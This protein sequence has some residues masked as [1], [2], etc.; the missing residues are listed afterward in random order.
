MSDYPLLLDFT[1]LNESLKNFHRLSNDELKKQDV[2]QAEDG[3]LNFGGPQ[4]TIFIRV[5]QVCESSFPRM[6]PKSRTAFV[7]ALN[8]MRRK[9]DLRDPEKEKII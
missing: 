6:Q 1:N 2:S 3:N 4:T 5:L 7:E 9:P 8:V